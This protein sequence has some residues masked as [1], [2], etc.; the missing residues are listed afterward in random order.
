V[1]SSN[2]TSIILNVTDTLRNDIYNFPLT[3]DIVVPDDW[4]TVSVFQG[5]FYDYTASY[6]S[7]SSN[8]IQTSI[9]PDNGQLILYKGLVSGIKPIARGPET[10]RLYQNYPNP[11]NPETIIS[12]SLPEAS[13][14]SLIIFNSLGEEVAA[15]VSGYLSGGIHKINFHPGNLA[16]GIYYYRL[17]SG[18]YSM[19][20]KMLLLK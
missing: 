7:G 15:L 20:K 3:A 8:I 13:N 2:D 9:V 12:F 17:I 19:V 16:S 11:F 5:S 10:F 6:F 1:V 14:T 18:D 4:A